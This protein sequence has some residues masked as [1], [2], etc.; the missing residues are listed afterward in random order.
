MISAMGTDILAAFV[1]PWL[2]AGGAA[3]VAGPILIHLLA[4]RRFRRVRWA[5]IEFL[6]QAER[7]N[8]RRIRIEQL[9]LL[10]LRCLAMV[11]IG[12]FVAR[13][14]LQPEG[15]AS[16]L[17]AMPR[18]ER[19]I[20]LDDSFSMGYR[21][22]EEST[23]DVAKR[24][25][26][27]LLTWAA[28]ERP[29]DSVTLVLSSSAERPAIERAAIDAGTVE[30]WRRVLAGLN[31]S[32][33]R[34]SP[35]DALAAV[36]GLLDA[37]GD[38]VNVAVYVVSDFQRSDWATPSK[39]APAVPDESSDATVDPLT[40][41]AEWPGEQRTIELILVDVG[42]E[43]APNL[44]ISDLRGRQIRGR[45]PQ[46]VA[47]VETEFEVDVTNHSGRAV[48]NRELNVFLGDAALPALIVDAIGPGQTVTVPI[49]LTFPE[50]G[51]AA[52]RVE[53]GGDGLAIDDARSTAVFV[54]PAVDILLVNG[55]P[56]PE[57][58]LDEVTTLEA[59]L[60]PEGTT[61][62]GNRVR[63]V[64]DAELEEVGLDA[65]HLV[66]LANVYRV[67]EP[68]VESL[69]RFVSAGGGLL[70]FLGDQVD[71]DVYNRML[72]RDGAGLLPARL[73]DQID[74]PTRAGVGFGPTALTHPI[75]RMLQGQAS[76]IVGRIHFWS[77]ASSIPAGT[78][79]ATQD[80]DIE[81]ARETADSPSNA[82]GPARVVLA[83]NDAEQSPAILER[84]FGRGRVVL[85][86]T[87]CDSDWN[88][89][90]ADPSYVI[91]M[92][93]LAHYAARADTTP[94]SVLV[95]A[96]IQVDLPVDRY[97]PS[98]VLRRPGYP[99]TPQVDVQATTGPDGDGFVLRWD[100]T[101]QS[102]VYTFALT[103]RTGSTDRRSVAV[104]VDARESDLAKMAQ[105]ELEAVMPDGLNVTYVRNQALSDTEMSQAR[106]EYWPTALICLI[107][108]LMAEQSLAWWFGR[109][110]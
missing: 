68:A 104:N 54:R 29:Q 58:Y 20:V 26:E 32:Q 59:A 28:R 35:R 1:T 12:L 84:G 4:R 106:Q 44:A 67:S 83:F 33:R 102:G 27:Q 24:S 86:T 110:S 96:P 49:R 71:N 7:R 108:V 50:P 75:T 89:W 42:R 103:G 19:I 80:G 56:S 25:I 47:G 18:T 65:Y 2:F 40:S 90:P 15:L 30:D 109:R 99:I 93:E 101:E 3:A 82:Q 11:L 9:I 41:L 72:F 13:P 52:V 37:R 107:A 55:A 17:G 95:G 60:Q 57:W 100:R 62:S 48:E 64:D 43:E 70:V 66:V 21:V 81:A 46:T 22:G 16:L 77:Y 98:A 38:A 34:A 69:E 78:P 74:T 92:L 31:P 88:D 91:L 5:A 63:V 36:R 61:I 10:A 14:F 6:R 51:S 76:A 79:G 23:F 8:R 97:E 45:Q 53:T 105:A 39:A 87:S 73:G 85:V 94:G